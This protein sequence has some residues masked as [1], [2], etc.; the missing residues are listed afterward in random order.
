MPATSCAR[1]T[2]RPAYEPSVRATY[3]STAARMMP[4]AAATQGGEPST[5]NARTG[6]DVGPEGGSVHDRTSAPVDRQI[7]RTEEPEGPMTKPAARS[8]ILRMTPPAGKTAK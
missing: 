4:A 3:R 5:V 7:S 6:R 8:V 2:V 1:P